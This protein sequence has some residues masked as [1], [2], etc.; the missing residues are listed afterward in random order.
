[1][2]RNNVGSEQLGADTLQHPQQRIVCTP[3]FRKRQGKTKVVSQENHLV[4]MTV[5][6]T[7]PVFDGAQGAPCF[8]HVHRLSN[9]QRGSPHTTPI[10]F[11]KKTRRH[12]R[13]SK[14]LH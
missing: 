7:R 14:I 3:S 4:T 10:F 9:V 6:I 11:I 2:T 8:A 13:E 12:V 1:M 5:D